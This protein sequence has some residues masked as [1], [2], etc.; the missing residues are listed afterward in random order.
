MVIRVEVDI[1]APADLCFDLAR[2]VDAHVAS[3][4]ATGEQ[5]VAG[6]TCG[7]LNLNNLR[8]LRR[9][10]RHATDDADE[11]ERAAAGA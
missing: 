7:L 6:V 1:A 4:G 10:T 5:V 2:C 9:L 8:P 11:P 3:A